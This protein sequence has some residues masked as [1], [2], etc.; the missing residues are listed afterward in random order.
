M[1]PMLHVIGSEAEPSPNEY[2]PDKANSLITLRAPS[3]T[4]G[5]RR[6]GTNLWQ[7][8]RKYMRLHS[9]R[10]DL[11]NLV[12]KDM[13]HCSSSWQPLPVMWNLV[14]QNILMQLCNVTLCQIWRRL[15]QR[16]YLFKAVKDGQTD[17]QFI[18]KYIWISHLHV[19][20]LKY[21]FTLK[22]IDNLSVRWTDIKDHLHPKLDF[23]SVG[24]YSNLDCRFQHHFFPHSLAMY[25]PMYRI[26]VLSSKFHVPL[27]GMVK[28]YRVINLSFQTLLPGL[29][30]TTQT[31]DQHKDTIPTSVYVTYVE[32]SLMC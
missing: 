26:T 11:L 24:Y 31:S 19:T 32:K 13:S 25:R 6:G 4:H 28:W 27:Y 7:S 21:I 5:R 1:F 15:G 22:L 9:K 18:R 14:Y 30:S 8:A 12:D 29:V 2:N 10:N 16:F 17:R 23:L 3:F 20:Y